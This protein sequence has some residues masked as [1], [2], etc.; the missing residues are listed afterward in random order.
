MIKIITLYIIEKSQEEQSKLDKF[1][2]FW[3]VL[4]YLQ[5]FNLQI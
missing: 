4:H 3:D 5:S 1:L 2:F